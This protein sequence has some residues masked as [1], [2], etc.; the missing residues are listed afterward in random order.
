M[1]SAATVAV[2]GWGALAFGA[3]YS[4][5]YTPLLV[6]CLAVGLLGLLAPSASI[7]LSRSIAVALATIVA[8]GV[9]QVVPLPRGVVTTLSPARLSTDYRQLYATAIPQL[10][11]QGGK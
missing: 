3:E 10:C 1:F 6:L 5:A 11:A 4:W 9:F 8:A 7:P 2:L